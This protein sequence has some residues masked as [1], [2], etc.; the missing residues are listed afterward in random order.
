MSDPFEPVEFVAETG[1]E[2]LDK[3]LAARF[4][5]L[6]RSQ[7]QTLIRDG[8]VM[9]N[10]RPGKASYRVEGGEQVLVNVPVVEVAPAPRPEAIPLDVLYEDESVAVINKPAGMVVHPAVGHAGG[11]LVNG[12]LARWP[13]IAAFG[14][15]DRAG[16]V[17]RLDKETSGVIVIAKT[18]TAL[19]N[20]RQQF[21]DRA[22]SKRYIA[23]VD[24]VPETSEGVIDAPI[25]RDTAQRK[26][27]SVV[28]DGRESMTEFRVLETFNDYALIEAFPKTGRTHQIRV[29]MAFV[30][31][32]VVGDTVYGRRKQGLKMKRH[33]L[34]AAS[35]TFAQPDT[36]EPITVEAPLPTSLQAVLDRLPR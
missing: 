32:P 18:L 21:K 10:G 36:G 6:S 26:R 13:E 5:D 17:H 22:I 2:R 24:G 3:M 35:I 28:R 34:H 15:V 11:T 30:D 33:F 31:H 27:M 25:G 9:V 19:E 12:V 4:A 23:L 14:E 8:Q 1:G 7:I 16:I 29:H 20:L